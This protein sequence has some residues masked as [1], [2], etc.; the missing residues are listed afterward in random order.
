VG[1]HQISLSVLVAATA[2][3]LAVGCGINAQ[4]AEQETSNLKPLMVLYGRYIG[5]H[6]GQPPPNEAA[7]KDFVKS[8][9]TAELPGGAKDMD[10]LFTSTRDKQ[11]YVIIYGP[12]KGSTGP[13]GQPVVAYEQ[14]GVNGRRYVASMLGAIEEVD[15]GK[16]RE[17]VPDAK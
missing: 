6:R 11:P 13:G 17:L 15:E 7:F 10:A 14:A 1:E 3:L 16:F 5:Q 2:S 4:K 9:G 8:A 12:S